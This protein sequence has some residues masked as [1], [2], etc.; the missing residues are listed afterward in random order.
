MKALKAGKHV[1]VE[2]PAGKNYQEIEP[3]L[4]F[5]KNS[6]LKLLVLTEHHKKFLK[7]EFGVFK[8]VKVFPNF[9]DLQHILNEKVE[10]QEG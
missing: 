3:V 7:E 9:I 4:D 5:L 2:K 8:N 6:K 1:L 10:K